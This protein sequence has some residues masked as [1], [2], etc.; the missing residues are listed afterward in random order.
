LQVFDDELQR[1]LTA[2]IKERCVAEPLPPRDRVTLAQIFD[3]FCANIDS[4]PVSKYVRLILLFQCIRMRVFEL[5]F[6]FFF[7]FRLVKAFTAVPHLLGGVDEV[8]RL[9]AQLEASGQ[10]SVCFEGTI[11][12]EV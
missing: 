5:V 10:S 8:R 12:F 9:V 11:L 1:R 3:K 6:F 2:T 7:F 4:V